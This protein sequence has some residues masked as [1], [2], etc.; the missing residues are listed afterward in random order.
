MK[1][2]VI[3]KIDLPLL[4]GALRDHGRLIGPRQKDIQF[5]FEEIED[6]SD[7]LAYSDIFCAPSPLFRTINQA[8]K[9]L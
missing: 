6:A 9:Q 5:V 1:A 7:R 4:V 3:S 8:N 2:L